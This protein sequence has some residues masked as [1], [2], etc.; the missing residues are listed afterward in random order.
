MQGEFYTE[1]GLGVQG[2]QQFSYN[3]MLN[4]TPDYVV[5]NGAVGSLTGANALKAKGGDRVR[6]YFGDGGPNKTSSFHVIG[7][8]FDEAYVEGSSQWLPNIQTTEVPAGGATMVEFKVEVPGSYTLV[9]HSL[10]RLL[11]GAAG[12]LVVEGKDNPEVFQEIQAGQGTGGHYPDSKAL[13]W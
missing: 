3:K 4:E 10:S 12:Q 2:L 13:K 11:R 7:E 6:I 9:D 5:F 8:I 1:G